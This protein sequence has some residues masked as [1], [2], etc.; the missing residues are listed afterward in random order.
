MGP[1]EDIGAKGVIKGVTPVKRFPPINPLFRNFGAKKGAHRGHHSF[2]SHIGGRLLKAGR[3]APSA[4]L[5]N[6]L[7]KAWGIFTPL[8]C[9]KRKGALPRNVKSSVSFGALGDTLPGGANW[10]RLSQHGG[11]R[12]SLGGKHTPLGG[13]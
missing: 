1:L 7:Y 6:F 13:G 5:K 12:P 11:E 3:G 4:P 10:G 8:V 2:L 9:V